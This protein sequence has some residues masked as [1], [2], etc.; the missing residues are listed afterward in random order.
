[1]LGSAPCSS[2]E[3]SAGGLAACQPSPLP[4][5]HRNLQ[6]SQ[7]RRRCPPPTLSPAAA[8]PGGRPQAAYRRCSEVSRRSPRFDELSLDD[9]GSE[10]ETPS[11]RVEAL[12]YR[13]RGSA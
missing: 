3:H 8:N 13:F 5:H 1:M 11:H 12:V 4:P 6:P 9:R 10:R 7:S 2:L